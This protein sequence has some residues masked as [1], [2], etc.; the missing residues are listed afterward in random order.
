MEKVLILS[1]TVL[2]IILSLI[3][4]KGYFAFGYC[5]C[6]LGKIDCLYSLFGTSRL[7]FTYLIFQLLFA[8]K[9]IRVFAFM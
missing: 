6:M 2:I 4:M 7:K 8:L 3:K 5:V 1:L 9:A